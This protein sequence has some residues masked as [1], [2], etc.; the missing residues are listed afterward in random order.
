MPFSCVLARGLSLADFATV[1]EA[2]IL[3][4]LLVERTLYYESLLYFLPLHV[5]APALFLPPWDGAAL[6][7]GGRSTGH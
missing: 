6:Q 5:F 4:P 3:E 2:N 7:E 1:T